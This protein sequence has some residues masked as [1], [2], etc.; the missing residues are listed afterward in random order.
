M[1]NDKLLFI[2]G[3]TAWLIALFIKINIPAR[4]EAA[5]IYIDIISVSLVAFL[6][7]KIAFKGK[8]RF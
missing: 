2:L 4:S 6:I 5:S 1:N 8:F 3:L 7:I